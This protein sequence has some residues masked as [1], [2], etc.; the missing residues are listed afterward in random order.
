MLDLLVMEKFRFG[1]LLM[2]D[3]GV[4]VMFLEVVLVVVVV[5][6]VFVFIG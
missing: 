1:M 6:C 2:V 5:E 3:G 4:V